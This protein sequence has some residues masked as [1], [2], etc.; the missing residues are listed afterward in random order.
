MRADRDTP[1]CRQCGRYERV[2]LT[3][4][5]CAML[6]QPVLASDAACRDRTDVKPWLAWGVAVR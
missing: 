2:S 3:F 1:T 5:R 4:E 6:G